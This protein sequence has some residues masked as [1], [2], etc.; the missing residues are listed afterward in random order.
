[1][2]GGE[3]QRLWAGQR[4][5]SGGRGL[6]LSTEDQGTIDRGAPKR[7]GLGEGIRISLDRVK[8]NIFENRR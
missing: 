6:T 2:M 5:G 7:D 1:M 4:S 8:Y 3:A